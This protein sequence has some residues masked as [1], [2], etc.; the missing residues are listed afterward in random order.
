MSRE[1]APELGDTQAGGED[2][3][4][5]TPFDRAADQLLQTIHAAIEGTT[6]PEAERESAR[7][8]FRELFSSV[9][10]VLKEE[11]RNLIKPV[12]RGVAVET[13]GTVFQNLST[14]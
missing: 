9:G 8:V 12:D 7:A 3:H 5:P 14:R 1:G 2:W 13:V 6:D 11:G 4:A 10:Y